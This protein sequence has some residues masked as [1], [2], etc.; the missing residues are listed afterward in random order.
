[1][2]IEY[3]QKEFYPSVREESLVN[4]QEV[5]QYTYSF[6]PTECAAFCSECSTVEN[7]A[8]LFKRKETKRI[9]RLPPAPAAMC[10]INSGADR[11]REVN[12]LADGAEDQ[13]PNHI[14]VLRERP[15]LHE[16]H[17]TPFGFVAPHAT[18]HST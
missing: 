17:I 13:Y 1:M 11:T 9:Q 10:N 3:N 12:D 16:K 7:C 4:V 8:A 2:R 15:D 18:S 6:I 14:H 5:R